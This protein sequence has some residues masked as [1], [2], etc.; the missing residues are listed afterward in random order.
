MTGSVRIEHLDLASLQSVR[1]F[2]DRWSGPLDLLVNNAGVMTPPRFRETREHIE[3]QFGTNHLGHF[4]LTVLLLPLLLRSESGRVVTVSSIAHRAGNSKVLYGSPR[5]GYQPQQAYAQSKLANLLFAMELHRRARKA[6]VPLAS[7]A[8]HPGVT[9]TNLVTSTD[10]LGDLPLV[11]RFASPLLRLAFQ[12]PEAG[13]LPTLYAATVADSGT[14]T[15]PQHFW[16]MR[17]PV[18]PA[19]MSSAAQDPELAQR[20]WTLSEKWTGVESRL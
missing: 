8:A 11:R 15:G 17:G 18:G 9:A 10:G 2:A 7:T 12:S 13:A 4:A 16:E 6:G 19:G 14:F 5:A 20:L 3:L 1:D